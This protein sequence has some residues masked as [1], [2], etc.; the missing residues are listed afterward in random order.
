MLG[1]R[2]FGIEQLSVLLPREE[3]GTFGAKPE[4]VLPGLGVSSVSKRRESWLFCFPKDSSNVARNPDC[5]PCLETSS[6]KIQR[7]LY[8]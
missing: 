1:Y 8:P 7:L 4:A 5:S 6:H 3:P 2:L